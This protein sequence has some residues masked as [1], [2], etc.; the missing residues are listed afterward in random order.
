MERI[1]KIDL[2]QLPCAY[3]ISD[4][5]YIV[6]FP[7]GSRRPTPQNLLLGSFDTFESLELRIWFVVTSASPER[8][9]AGGVTRFARGGVDG[10]SP[11]LYRGATSGIGRPR[12][13]VLLALYAFERWR[14][15]MTRTCDLRFRKPFQ[16]NNVNALS[17]SRCNVLHARP[18]QPFGRKFIPDHE[19]PLRGSNGHS[20]DK[21]LRLTLIVELD[22][23]PTPYRHFRFHKR[24]F[25]ENEQ[26]SASASAIRGFPT[27][28]TPPPKRAPTTDYGALSAPCSSQLFVK[29]L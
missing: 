9:R 5:L 19:R 12:G 17:S 1:S 7:H 15:G 28:N 10:C 20:T 14:S 27:G 25:R 13:R 21:V 11:V 3:R 2:S 16:L 4:R 18:R 26:S 24:L 29:F 6:Q 22:S 23:G 8:G